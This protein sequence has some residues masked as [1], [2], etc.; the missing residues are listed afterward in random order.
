MIIFWL[1]LDLLFYNYTTVSTCF[2]LLILFEKNLSIFE[3]ILIGLI[4]DFFILKTYYIFTI[5]LICLYFL[6]KR[7]KGLNLSKIRKIIKLL[8]LSLLFLFF[9]GNFE[10][11]IIGYILNFIIIIVLNIK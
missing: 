4:W 1:L 6:S 5:L 10:L 11:Y 7:L 3:M 9:F 8:I 2:F